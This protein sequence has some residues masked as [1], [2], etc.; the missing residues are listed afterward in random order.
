[1][2]FHWGRFTLL[3][4]VVLLVQT[5]LSWITSLRVLDAFLLLVLLVSLL[6]PDHDSR[7]AAWITGLFQDLASADP[8]GLHAFSLGLTALIL[9]R[10]RDLL[11]LNV[12]WLRTAAC[13]LAAL[14]GQLL[15]GLHVHFWSGH[16]IMSAFEIA[17]AAL[18]AAAVASLVAASVTGMPRF[19]RRLRARRT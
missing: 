9:T 17:L 15:C 16:G 6:G 19:A 1:M 4:L 5:G 18:A 2:T 11:N 12:S 3:L 8:L 7:L 13:L 10:L 14:P